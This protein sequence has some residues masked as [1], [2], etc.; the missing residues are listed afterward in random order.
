MNKKIVW[1]SIGVILVGVGIFYS[2]IYGIDDWVLR[3]ETQ[4]TN[5][6][7][8]YR[9]TEMEKLR[10][11]PNFSINTQ[12]DELKLREKIIIDFYENQGIKI[13]DFHMRENFEKPDSCEGCNCNAGG[14]AFFARVEDSDKQFLLKNGWT[15]ALPPQI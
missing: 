7:D 10:E 9:W 11:D 2:Q 1:I 6:W 5:P 13:L 3:V 4:C 8:E 15:S 14:H 12:I